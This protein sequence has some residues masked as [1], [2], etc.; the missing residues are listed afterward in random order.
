MISLWISVFLHSNSINF[1]GAD[2][3]NPFHWQF[4]CQDQI[5]LEKS[6]V[7]LISYLLKIRKGLV[8]NHIL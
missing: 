7:C 1:P 4:S 5:Y 8:D 3:S 6:Q 2:V